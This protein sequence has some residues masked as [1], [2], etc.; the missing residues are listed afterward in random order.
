MKELLK[1]WTSSK[2][3]LLLLSNDNQTEIVF[4]LRK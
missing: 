4:T 2:H 1:Q 3:K